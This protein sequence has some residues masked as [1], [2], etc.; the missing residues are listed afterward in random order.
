M[1]IGNYLDLHGQKSCLSC[2]D[3][4]YQMSLPLCTKKGY[5]KR[6]CHITHLK[7]SITSQHF[8]KTFKENKVQGFETG[9]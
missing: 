5:V 3:Q 1:W 2:E 8:H 6:S 7:Y 4:T 9:H